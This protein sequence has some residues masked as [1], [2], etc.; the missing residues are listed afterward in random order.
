MKKLISNEAREL[1]NI[2]V[3]LIIQSMAGLIIGFTDQ[4]MVG[5]ISI[6]AYSAVGVISS[7]LSLLAGVLGFTSVVFNINGAKSLGKDDNVDFQDEFISCLILNI[8]IG[9]IFFIIIVLFKNPLLTLLYGF[10]GKIL[11]EAVTYLNIMSVYI[12]IQLLLF[13]FSALFKIKKITKWILIGSTGSSIINLILDYGLIFGNLGLPKLE[14]KGAAIATILS[15]IINLLFYVCVCRKYIQFN[16]KKINIYKF[17]IKN[18]I[19]ESIPLM[20]QEVLEGS[21][22]IIATNAIISR[23]G[24]IE[25]STYLI[26]TQLINIILI[27]M[28]MYGSATLTLISQ[29]DGS[30]NKESL[31]N[32]PKLSILISMIIYLFLSIL[33]LIFRDYLPKLI[34]N[35]E[36]VILI[37]SNLLIY[38]IISNIFNPFC[39]IYK[40]SL[41][42]LNESKFVLFNTAKVNFLS[43]FLMC[44]FIYILKIQIYGIF[45]S[46]FVNYFIV[47]MIYLKKYNSCIAKKFNTYDIENMKIN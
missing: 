29:N 30:N 11:D 39:T 45:I 41:Q 31:T 18:N 7:L 1:N 4:A 27:P 8:L 14:I 2:A 23:I 33:F 16:Y 9:L 12:I 36:K 13:S 34:T 25:L 38:I 42:S 21:I 20:G 37:A 24:V 40:Y 3:P 43:L 5:R 35:D 46:L 44:F 19:K 47:F 10:K 26:L 32:I 15:L 6:F 28:Y 22:F 17:K